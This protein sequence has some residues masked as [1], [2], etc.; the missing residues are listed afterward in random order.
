MATKTCSCGRVLEWDPSIQ[1][2]SG[3]MGRYREAAT[4]E[5]HNCPNWKPGENKPYSGPATNSQANELVEIQTKLDTVLELLK[6]IVAE[7]SYK[8]A[9]EL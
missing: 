1:N 9:T 8:K 7:N 4:G 5:I 3:K 6:A 2:K